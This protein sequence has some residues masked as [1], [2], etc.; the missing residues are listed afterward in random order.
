M[1]EMDVIHVSGPPFRKGTK[2]CPKCGRFMKK[3]Y[4]HGAGVHQ[5]ICTQGHGIMIGDKQWGK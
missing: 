3:E 2:H 1:M 5:Y 4:I